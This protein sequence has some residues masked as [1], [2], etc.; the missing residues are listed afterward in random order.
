M[1]YW[2][3]EIYF[4][5]FLDP[6]IFT[7]ST[8]Y[9]H[10]FPCKRYEKKEERKNSI[11]TKIWNDISIKLFFFSGEEFWQLMLCYRQPYQTSNR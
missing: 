4:I 6:I 8:K 3:K 5:K 11:G 1:A 7:V 9:Q 2:E 10:F